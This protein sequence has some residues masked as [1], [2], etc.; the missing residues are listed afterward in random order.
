MKKIGH[1]AVTSSAF[2]EKRG[3]RQ[4]PRHRFA[5]PRRH[6]HVPERQPAFGVIP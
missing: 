1:P 4:T 6:I 2:G 3:F 5:T